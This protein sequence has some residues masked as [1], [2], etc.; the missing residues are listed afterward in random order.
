MDTSRTAI[1][2]PSSRISVAEIL[3]Y[4]GIT[5]VLYGTFLLLALS[6]PSQDEVGLV[7]LVLTVV[8]LVTGAAVGTDAPDRIG[9]LRSVSWYLS[10]SFFSSMLQAWLIS[11]TSL[12]SG[13]SSLLPVFVPTAVY[14]LALWLF[15]PRLLQQ[16]AFYSAVLSALVV[17]VAPAPTSFTFGSPDLSGVALVL[18]LGGAGWFALG[19]AGWVRPPRAALVLGM[20]VSVP[21]PLIFAKDSVEV[22]FLLVLATAAVY[23]FL[24]GRLADRAVTG[25]GAVGV[26]VGLVGF[27]VAVGADDR[28]WASVVLALGA[29]LLIVAILL[30]RRFGGPRATF[31]SPTFPLGPRAG[32]PVMSAAPVVEEAPSMPPPPAVESPPDDAADESAPT[33]PSPS[34]D[35][36][37]EP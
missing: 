1:V 2:E 21:A 34:D 4:L 26:V 31:G 30:A 6:S 3:A 18:W 36:P 7:S 35:E 20:L 10:V 33:E 8:F 24:G 19:Y 22:A 9:R 16:L 25:I 27:L 32:A 5:G 28:P 15:L 13:F 14:A 12:L 11:P 29:G 37:R 17:L 23:V